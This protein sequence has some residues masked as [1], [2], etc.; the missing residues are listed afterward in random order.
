MVDNETASGHF[1]PIDLQ[2]VISPAPVA[3]AVP[4]AADCV[5]HNLQTGA[6]YRLNEVGARIWELV[7]PGCTVSAIQAQLCAEYQLPDDVSPE[8]IQRDVVQV[9]T[10]LRTYGLLIVVP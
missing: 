2:G 7:E 9:L 6:T 5:V 4:G 8:Q 3:V 1:P 10:E